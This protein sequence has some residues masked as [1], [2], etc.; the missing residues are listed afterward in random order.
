MIYFYYLTIIELVMTDKCIDMLYEVYKALFIVL[1]IS[2]LFIELVCGFSLNVSP[3]L[4]IVTFICT[5]MALCPMLLMFKI[6]SS[7]KNIEYAICYIKADKDVDKLNCDEAKDSKP[8]EL[9]K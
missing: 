4:V 6:V 3:Y 5:L 9:E 1:V 7:L 8:T 2:L